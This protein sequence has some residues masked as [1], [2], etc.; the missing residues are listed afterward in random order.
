MQTTASL[1][2]A[3]LAVAV[4]LL[5]GCGRETLVLIE[6][7][8]PQAAVWV[9][10]E[11]RGP[12]PQQVT[13]PAR[14]EVHLR[15]SQPGY[16]NWETVLTARNVPRLGRLHVA[17]KQEPSCAVECRSQPPGA[18]VYVDGELCGRTPVRLTDLSPGTVAL[19]FRMK[20]RQQVEQRLTLGASAADTHVDIRLPSLAEAYYLQ[21]LQDDP[22]KMPAFADL[23]H[24]YVLEKRF[25]DA[26]AV[27]ARGIRVVLTVPG[28]DASRLWS[29]VQRVVTVQYQYGSE[30]EV[31]AARESLRRMIELLLQE[32]P[33]GSG[34]L[35]A[36]YAEV[37]DVL[38]ERQKA[39][40]AFTAGRR[41]HPDDRELAAVASLTPSK[42]TM[43]GCRIPSGSLKVH[44]KSLCSN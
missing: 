7:T 4:L 17:L 14:G 28:I 19:V 12:A 25:D 13:V 10:S 23:G 29:E 34:P 41:L 20:G 30:E 6:S 8:P 11:L 39:E 44:H 32:Y 21:C 26:M 33:K 15:V 18:E 24:H 38:G 9:D 5:A 31:K 37:L 1:V 35:Y 16:Q 2:R 3:G 22:H 43:E 27:F 42:K 40:E 36:R